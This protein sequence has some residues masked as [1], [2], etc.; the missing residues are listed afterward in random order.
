M[1]ILA[2]LMMMGFYSGSG[3]LYPYDPVY[4]DQDGGGPCY[5]VMIYLPKS[6]PLPKT[7]TWCQWVDIEA[8]M[9]NIYGDN[10]YWW[11]PR[12]MT[13]E[14]KKYLGDR[15]CYLED[16]GSPRNLNDMPRD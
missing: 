9:K 7:E 3:T 15:V 11:K 10:W 12:I 1:I 13:D 14:R 5:G 4:C 16:K 8:Q 2:G 6:A